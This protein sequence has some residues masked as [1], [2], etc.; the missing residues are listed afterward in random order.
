VLAHCLTV[1]VDRTTEELK[2]QIAEELLLSVARPSV[3]ETAQACVQC[4]K[5]AS[6]GT[7]HPATQ[8]PKGEG[9]SS[10]PHY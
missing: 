9:F 5:K 3:T 7:T 4:L 10:A 2:L 8:Q 1:H 6:G